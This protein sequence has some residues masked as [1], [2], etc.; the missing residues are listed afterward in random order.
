M[1]CHISNP[2]EHEI[3]D[4]I[5]AFATN[6]PNELEI[7]REAL[8]ALPKGPKSVLYRDQS[9]GG[10]DCG[11]DCTK[12]EAAIHTHGR[13][14]KSLEMTFTVGAELARYGFVRSDP[15][16]AIWRQQ[17]LILH[18]ADIVRA[19]GNGGQ[20][21]VT[22]AIT[23]ALQ[24]H[25]GPVKHFRVDSSQIP[26]GREQLEEWLALLRHK[27]VEEIVLVN[28]RWPCD[29]IEFPINDLNCE[30]ISQLRLCFFRISDIVLTYVENLTTI[31]FCFCSISA[32][33][34]S[35]LIDQSKNLKELSI[36][37]YDG[38]VIR[39]TSKS[40]EI[41]LIW[42]STIKRIAVKTAS[43]LRRVLLSARPKKY[44]IGVWINSAPVLTDLCINLSDPIYY[45]QQ[46]FPQ[47]GM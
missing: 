34:L 36:G 16:R 41:L 44:D 47:D 25:P 42:Q 2:A 27:G 22:Q 18:D 8:M 14:S 7:I 40:L 32:Q 46:H 37:Y 20:V 35:A 15:W 24:N 43:K 1:R 17:A 45:Y 28:S 19:V 13:G 11:G 4:S 3:A 33:D 38:D 31:D 21:D 30:S 10:G 9:S 12:T 23:S 29:M 26:K 39:I 5:A 6:K